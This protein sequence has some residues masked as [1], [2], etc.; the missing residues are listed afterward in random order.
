MV[1]KVI[2]FPAPEERFERFLSK[3][4]EDSSSYFHGPAGE[5][6][7]ADIMRYT[8]L[9]TPLDQCQVLLSRDD[10]TDTQLEIVREAIEPLIETIRKTSTAL[11][12]ELTK[13]R[14]EKAASEI[15]QCNS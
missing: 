8:E 7:I 11:V 1:K 12:L 2:N 14:F 10:F 5:Q 3:T 6:I 15:I 4:I 13:L 9:V